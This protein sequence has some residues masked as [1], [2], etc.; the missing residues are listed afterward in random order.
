M[1]KTL[2]TVDVLIHDAFGQVLLIERVKEPFMDKLVMPG[3]HV[4]SG[5]SLRQAAVRELEEEIGV[6]LAPED[7]RE[8]CYLD[9]SDRD[10]RHER[11][12]SQVYDVFVPSIE[13]LNARA[14]SDAK[15]IRVAPLS[16]LTSEMIGFD[17]YQAVKKLREK[18][19]PVSESPR[20]PLEDIPFSC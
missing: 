15:C 8:L 5:E 10:P 3:G 7:L 20:V 11:R 6:V 9:A 16:F 1:G 18:L 17:H 2:L 14:Q 12:E 13:K 19:T 4:E